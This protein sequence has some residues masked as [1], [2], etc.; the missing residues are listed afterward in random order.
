M[1]AI[2]MP[3]T[4]AGVNAEPKLKDMCWSNN[5]DCRRS[6]CPASNGTFPVQD[7]RTGLH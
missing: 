3:V 1:N 2:P 7:G 5:R 6:G 4:V